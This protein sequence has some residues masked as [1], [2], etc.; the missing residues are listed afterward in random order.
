[1]YNLDNKNPLNLITLY[2]ILNKV[3][4]NSYVRIN[5]IKIYKQL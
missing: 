1:M 2:K 3:I 4:E 5:K